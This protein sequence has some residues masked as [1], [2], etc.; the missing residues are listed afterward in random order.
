MISN[1]KILQ[2]EE[3]PAL[4]PVN[5]HEFV[6][7]KL[8]FLCFHFMRSS[9]DDLKKIGNV[10]DDL[11][12]FIKE[13]IFICNNFLQY[14]DS[15]Y[16]IICFNRD[17]SNGKGERDITYMLIC[18]L[19]KH[20]PDKATS[21]VNVLPN[22]GSWADIKYFCGFVNFHGSSYGLDAVSI[23]ALINHA[24]EI[25]VF[26]FRYDYNLWNSV[27]NEYLSKDSCSQR[28]NAKFIISNVAK[29]IPREKNKYGW[30]FD[31]IVE[32]YFNTS[33]NKYDSDFNL[34]KKR[35]IF[36]KMVSSL[37]REL[38]VL[39]R[40]LCNNKWADIEYKNINLGAFFTYHK[41][42]LEGRSAYTNA[43]DR[44]LCKEFMMEGLLNN[45]F[46]NTEDNNE[47]FIRSKR[48]NVS[49]GKL[50]KMGFDLIKRP[51]TQVV[52]SQ[53]AFVNNIWKKVL[54]KHGNSGNFGKYLLPIIDSSIDLSNDTFRQIIG[55]SLFTGSVSP[56]KRIV[57]FK[58]DFFETLIVDESLE[59]IDLLRNFVDF[60]RSIYVKFSSCIEK[61]Y[62]GFNYLK[63][64]LKIIFFSNNKNVFSQEFS[65]ISNQYT[66]YIFWN[67]GTC[68]F[69]E[70]NFE[71]FEKLYDDGA[72]FLSGTVLLDY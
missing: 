48:L 61:L 68:D 22:I 7:K 41:A 40:K 51:Y 54:K 42:L 23:S 37:C 65:L 57:V 32:N 49:M 29:W 63:Q 17:I 28:P 27:F 25:I 56:L 4:K 2:R 30:L 20:F 19:Y 39:E 72:R 31:K 58:N 24:V 66:N 9:H 71:M 21:C 5:H 8:D 64:P 46:D 70:C 33:D 6:S 16:S 52:S 36:R 11:L 69:N 18:V 50:V 26:Q 3:Y 12:Y 60:D 45:N 14:V 1:M 47:F 13:K 44:D 35:S 38:D 34:N 67:L 43:V 53:M 62:S 55:M 59:F 10:V 15:F